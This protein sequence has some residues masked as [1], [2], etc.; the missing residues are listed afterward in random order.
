MTEDLTWDLRFIMADQNG[1]G[2]G[3]YF[4]PT[5]LALANINPEGV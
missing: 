5:Q 1:Q 2:E 4:Y 3:G